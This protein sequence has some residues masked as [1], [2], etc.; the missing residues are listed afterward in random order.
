MVSNAKSMLRS[1]PSEPR[2][3]RF[4]SNSVAGGHTE[5]T[6]RCHLALYQGLER[7]SDSV[8]DALAWHSWR[9]LNEQ[10]LQPGLSK[11]WIQNG[12]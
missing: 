8:P 5:L 11:S 2:K 10:P 12:Y 3:G 1:V 9:E 7:H 6:G 4:P